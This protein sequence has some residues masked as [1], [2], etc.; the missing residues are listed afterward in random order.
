MGIKTIQLEDNV[1]YSPITHSLYKSGDSEN[2]V[3]LAIPASLCLLSLLQHK[4]EIVS[5]SDL[6]SFAWESRGMMVSPN[7]VY[8]NMSIL[9]KALESMGVSNEMI[10]TVPKRG[11][12][13]P[14]GFPVE[15]VYE[16][17]ES[18]SQADE[19]S[20]ATPAP[21]LHS[22]GEI[23]S[24][25]PSSAIPSA[26]V[27]VKKNRKRHYVYFGVACCMAFLIATA[28]TRYLG[29]DAIPAYIAPDF[30]ALGNVKDCQVF[31]NYSSRDDAFF[32][33]FIADKNVECGTQK[34]WY[35]TNYPP[36]QQVSILRC[37]KELTAP[38]SEKTP[39]CTSDFYSENGQQQ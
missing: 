24:F 2:Q 21:V 23:T 19:V 17:E 37:S 11:F 28:A 10:R 32:T 6:L 7:T 4:G 22:A 38:T 39:L 30:S 27:A 13:I 26:P 20:M 9:R 12:M 31:R 8:Q 35:I 25:P 34:W 14:A 5:H 29:D 18:I 33:K 3:A 1:V 15:F 36:S 16:N